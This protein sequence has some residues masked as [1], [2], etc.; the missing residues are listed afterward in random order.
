LIVIALAEKG[1][2]GWLW[3]GPLVFA[4]WVNFHG[5]F[6]A[7]LGFLGIWTIVHTGLHLKN[8]LKILPPVILSLLAVLVNPYGIDLIIFLLRTATIP[9]PEIVEWQPLAL[10]SIL[11]AIY[12]IL[13]LIMILGLI[14]SRLKKEIPIMV[15]LGVAALLPFVAFRHLPLFSLAVLVFCGEHVSNAMSR[16]PRTSTNAS[17]RSPLIA[18]ISVLLGIGLIFWGFRNWSN[19]SIP[20]QPI[21]FFPDKAVSL[22]E[23]SQVSGNMAVEFNWGEYVIWHLSP[24]IKVSVDGRRETVYST[25]IYEQNFD[26]LG[27]TGDWDILLD[28]YPT[29]IALVYQS[30]SA[31]NLMKLKAG[32]H[33]VYED[34]T[35]ALFTKNDWKGASKLDE[36]RSNFHPELD[37]MYFP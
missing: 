31:Y 30:Q 7:G 15:L 28:D 20:H 29:H 3:L 27:G 22:L 32:W 33:L 26:F 4:L 24:T 1:K 36:T 12:I 14:F 6:L 11:G 23:E 17:K 18:L 19:I 5:G 13:L 2:Y 34:A 37:N 8:W 35:S 21:P 10:V 16:I 25:E 9:R